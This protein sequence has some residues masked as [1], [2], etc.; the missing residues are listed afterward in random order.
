MNSA[1]IGNLTVRS[2]FPFIVYGEVR[3]LV[4]HHRTL[5]GAER[6]ASKDRA[7][8]RRCGGGAYSDVEVYEWDEQNGW[9]IA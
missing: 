5:S 6:S 1:Y 4:S 2:K 3:G 7:E 9:E 8:C